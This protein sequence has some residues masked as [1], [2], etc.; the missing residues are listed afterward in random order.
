MALDPGDGE[1]AHNERRRMPT[2][3]HTKNVLFI[4]LSTVSVSKNES[5]VQ[6]IEGKI[7]NYYSEQKN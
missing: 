3:K 2:I 7:K 5:N 6:A 1:I 4:V